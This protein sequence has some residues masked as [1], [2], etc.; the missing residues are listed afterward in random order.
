[1]KNDKKLRRQYML[2][3]LKNNELK[4]EKENSIYQ[5]LIH[6]PK[7]DNAQ[8]IGITLSMDHEVDT[9]FIIR[10]ALTQGKKVY[11]PKCN[12]KTK[13]MTFVR[14]TKP[15][16]LIIDDYGI[17]SMNHEIEIGTQPDLLIVPGVIFNKE[18]YRIGYG[19]GYFDKYLSQFNGETLSIL[20]DFQIDDV[21]VEPH[22]I[23]VQT[24]ITNKKRIEV[25]VYE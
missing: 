7:F 19:G 2:N 12:Y 3:V 25:E 14:Y 20:F 8:S 4:F 6:H 9:D 10:Y 23:P 17:E 24:L 5:H 16:D 18:G 15:D 13:Q 21:P 1:M 11:V 22:D